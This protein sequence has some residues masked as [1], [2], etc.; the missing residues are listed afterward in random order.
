MAREIRTLV[1]VYEDA[2]D[3]FAD[4]DAFG[5]K[6]GGAWEWTTYDELRKLIDRCRGGL[7]ALRV[8]PGDRV[9]IISDNR[10]EWAIVAY[11]TYGLEAVVVPMYEVQIAREW[12]HILEDSGAKVAFTS[13]PEIYE[14]ISEMAP[15]LPALEHIVCFD[16]P[17]EDSSSFAHLLEQGERSPLSPRI[18]QPDAVAGFIYTS[19]TTG[20]PKGVVLTHDNFVSNL[21][22]TREVFPLEPGEVSLAFLPW[23][24]SFGQTAELHYGLSQ[25]LSIAI[26]DSIAHLVDNLAEVKPT[27]LL[28]VPRIFN[29][30][31]DKVL[32]QVAEEPK[33]VQRMFSDGLQAAAKHRRGEKDSWLHELELKIDDRLIFSKV[34]QRF[35]GRLKF[36]ISASAALSREVAEFIDALGIEVYEG[37]GLSETSPVVSVNPPG[38]MRIG[39]VGKVIPGVRVEID[40]SYGESPGEGELIVYGPNVMK[41]YHDLPD[42][43]AEAFT[44]DGGFRTGDIGRFDED[45]YLYITGRIKEQY[46]LQTGKYVMPA[47]VEEQLKLSPYI[48]NLMLYGDA[49]PYN[50]A[51]V[52]PDRDA[53]D[54]WADENDVEI[55]DITTNPKVR[56]LLMSE[57]EAR[58]AELRPYELPKRILVTDEDFTPENGLLTPTMKL[59]RRAVVDRY[60][61]QLEALYRAEAP[62]SARA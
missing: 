18:P 11:A 7:A 56:D 31:Y 26:N 8:E 53:I 28:A 33:L 21:M 24:H 2:C 51:V 15:G 43:T 19:G 34:R 41:G 50:V 23:A 10:L 32:S 4:R 9:A 38:A 1:D 44:E 45:G 39:S 48:S 60:G 17:A 61:K 46:K 12:R 20:M 62:V 3:R 25:G 57:L 52:V 29:R 14:T 22:A 6:R 36:V 47:P 55:D 49:K 54:D 35:G 13:T 27:V 30:I 37:Y 59:K 42:K 5:T 16:L 40:E 58:G